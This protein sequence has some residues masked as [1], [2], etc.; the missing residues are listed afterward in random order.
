MAPADVAAVAPDAQ[1]V[2]RRLA[3]RLENRACFDCGAKNPTW[4]SARFGIFI[5]LDCSGMH[6]GLGTHVTFVRSA[7]MDTWSVH[8]L[9]CMTHGGN[10]RARQF[11]K[12]HGG[13]TTGDGFLADK[14]TGRVGAAYKVHLAR[15][16]AEA[17][18]V[19]AVTPAAEHA[20][21][22]RGDDVVEAQQQQRDKDKQGEEEGTR[23]GMGIPVDGPSHDAVHRVCNKNGATGTT[24]GTASSTSSASTTI[25]VPAPVAPDGTSI[26][27]GAPRRT[28]RAGGGGGG[29]GGARKRTPASTTAAG[30]ATNATRPTAVDWSKIGSDVAPGPYLAPVPAGSKKKLQ[31]EPKS[32]ASFG[33]TTTTAATTTT[34]A[35]ASDFAT[36]FAGKKSI[37]S[38]DFAPQ[39]SD[40]HFGSGAQQGS[41]ARF[42][43]SSSLSSTDYFNPDQASGGTAVGGLMGGGGLSGTQPHQNTY[44]GRAS[45]DVFTQLSRG[46]GEAVD[47]IAAN[48]ES[49]VS[50]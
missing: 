23:A 29:L 45:G 32:A 21:P 2:L 17:C 8:D 37:S 19:V 22:P 25:A 9:A 42:A 28:P 50:K 41:L 15:A 7:C 3:S 16:V 26:I 1:D 39:A 30:S 5:C 35:S 43:N 46:F 6:R 4:A 18:V 44:R 48:L 47:G 13:W 33:S 36:R 20:T 11:F 38:A 34:S 24:T 49:F 12:D 14:Y 10:A 27:A 31:Q 40:D